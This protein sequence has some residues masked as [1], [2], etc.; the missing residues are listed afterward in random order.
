MHVTIA[1]LIFLAALNMNRWL[2]WV[3]GL[4][5]FLI[6]VGS[7]QLGWH[8]AIDGY[9]GIGVA[10]L[11]WSLAGPIAR[12]DL[13]RIA[14]HE[15]RLIFLQRHR[16]DFSPE[17][18]LRLVVDSHHEEGLAI[19][20]KRE[21][22]CRRRWHFDDPQELALGIHHHDPSGAEFANIEIAVRPE[23]DP[24][25][26]GIGGLADLAHAQEEAPVGKR[27]VGSRS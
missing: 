10:L 21:I 20:R 3:T 11:S 5:A 22:G 16:V 14:E 27:S 25:R 9:L 24:V 18:R 17:G 2:A 19:L 4:F 13:N 12:W 15:G 26:I 6:L 23:L 1:V 7:V 8:Y